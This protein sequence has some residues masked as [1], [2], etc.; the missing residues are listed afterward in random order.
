MKAPVAWLFIGAFLA[1]CATFL[2]APTAMLAIQAVTG[3]DGF[4]LAYIE[5][6]GQYRYRVAFEHSLYLSL[7]SATAGVVAGG[8]VAFAVLKP[9]APAWL[10]SLVTSFSAVAANFAG[11]PLAFAFISTLGT[12][13]LLT[14]L[15]KRIGLDLYDM[16]FSLFSI[17]G[18]TLTY[19]YFQIP[20]MV[21]IITPAIAALRPS[22]REAAEILGATPGQYWR[23]VG[24]PVL[25]PSLIAAWILL[26]GNAFS[27]YA[28]AY[29]LTSGN[30]GLV[31]TEISAVLSGNVAADPQ[32]GAALSVGM[33]VV[34]VTVLAISTAMTRRA[35]RWTARS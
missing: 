10:R 23:H 3:E 15:L 6:L 7:A 18:L 35:S 4:T 2:V 27:A 28:T 29:A 19:S 26:F 17:T 20:L 30:I 16:G 14:M 13:G 21:I 12:L 25:A 1:V 5:T 11:V 31:T 22:W 9:G 32:I 8:L 33:I 24:L 34:M